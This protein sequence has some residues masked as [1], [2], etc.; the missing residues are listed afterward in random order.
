MRRVAMAVLVLMAASCGAP[1]TGP[2][3]GAGEGTICGGLSG[4]GCGAGLY[5]DTGPGQCTAAGAGTCRVRPQVCTAI[6]APVC[7]CDGETYASDCVAATA[8]V[9]VAAA[10]ECP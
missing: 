7:G 4:I 6:Y 2:R 5:C 1:D 9:T 8:G 10:G 3:S